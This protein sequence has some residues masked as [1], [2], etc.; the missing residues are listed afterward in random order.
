MGARRAAEVTQASLKDTFLRTRE[1]IR[2][3][4]LLRSAKFSV[5]KPG[6]FTF[7][8]EGFGLRKELIERYVH[9]RHGNVYV[10]L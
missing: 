8:D 10:N 1:E 7:C 6:V 9:K 5:D 4:I 3:I 2:I